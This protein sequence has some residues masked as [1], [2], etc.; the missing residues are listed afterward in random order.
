M[1]RRLRT[2]ALSSALCL[3]LATASTLLAQDNPPPPDQQSSGQQQG[4]HHHGPMSPDQELAHMTKALNLSSDQ[5][6]QLKP[7]L[8]N[9]SDQMQQIHQDSSLARPDKMAKMKVLD[10][11]LQHA[12]R[13][14]PERP[15]EGQVRKND[16]TAQRAYAPHAPG[17]GSG[18]TSACRRRCAAPVSSK[19]QSRFLRCG[20]LWPPVFFANSGLGGARG[21]LSVHGSECGNVSGR[22]KNTFL[23]ERGGGIPA[24]TSAIH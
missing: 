21:C 13:G 16:G 17:R 4:W 15:A 20:R 5:Q 9:R 3:G 11:Q 19:L 6:A 24:R 18:R 2:V 14:R 7:I 22:R 1:H 8:Q 10:G 23:S 12:G